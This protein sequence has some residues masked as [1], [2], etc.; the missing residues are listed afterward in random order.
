[1]ELFTLKILCAVVLFAISIIFGVLLPYLYWRISPKRKP[2]RRLEDFAHQDSEYNDQVVNIYGLL[3]PPPRS[4]GSLSRCFL[5]LK[6]KLGHPIV[7][8][9]VYCLCGGVF[10]GVSILDLFPDS[11]EAVDNAMKIMKTEIEYPI[12]EFM[13]AVGLLLVMIVENL[14]SVCMKHSTTVSSHHHLSSFESMDDIDHSV[15]T[16]RMFILVVTLSFH[17]LFEGL[18]IGLQNDE[19]TI[20]QLAVAISIHKAVLT[21]GV[22]LPLFKTLGEVDK[23]KVAVACALIFCSASPIGCVIGA[24]ITE[25]SYASS[26]GAAIAVAVL[27]CLATGTFLYV[28]FLEVLPKEFSHHHHGDHTHRSEEPSLNS[29]GATID[30]VSV[31]ITSHGTSKPQMLKLFALIVGFSIAAALQFLA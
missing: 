28:T 15:S 9:I 10:L 17:S 30:D 23:L 29:D 18:A 26:P 14:M 20:Y 13:I 8:S 16:Y 27:Q 19:G 5:L 2:L 12:T 1:M 24:F 25:Q 3:D 6:K 31:S 11:R 7:P 4:S 21:F 22:G